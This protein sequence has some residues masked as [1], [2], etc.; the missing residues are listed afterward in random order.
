[1]HH[2]TAT[3][4]NKPS[5]IKGG[6]EWGAHHLLQPILKAEHMCRASTHLREDYLK[7][8]QPAGAAGKCFP[9]KSKRMLV[10]TSPA[11]SRSSNTQPPYCP[12]GIPKPLLSPSSAVGIPET[13]SPVVSVD[14]LC[15]HGCSR[16]PLGQPGWD[17]DPL[18]C[19]GCSAQGTVSA[20]LSALGEP[21]PLCSCKKGLLHT[22]RDKLTNNPVCNK[23]ENKWELFPKC[24]S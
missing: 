24:Q 12:E 2:Q 16:E 23:W 5:E 11:V 9:D 4:E 22:L 21:P 15:P 17:L 7:S 6:G 10:Q 3:E 19:Q 18:H 14:Q 1:M 20:E 8:L 13:K